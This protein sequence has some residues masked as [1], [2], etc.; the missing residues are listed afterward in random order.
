MKA[1]PGGATSLLLIRHGESAANVAAATA[2]AAGVEVVDI[3]L[4]DADVPLTP[5]G[6]DQAEALGARLA[7]LAATEYP[8]SVWVSPYLRARETA[9]IALA[10]IGR[11][12]CRERVF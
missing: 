10:E 2:E 6:S 12:S 1:R 4:R 11:A 7:A 5:V 3:P 9:S 8:R